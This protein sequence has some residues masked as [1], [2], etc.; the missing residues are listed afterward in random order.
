M[1][2]RIDYIRKDGKEKFYETGRFADEIRLGY[3]GISEISL[4]PVS[5]LKALKVLSL[6][7]NHIKN[8]DLSPLASCKNLREIYLRGN[9]LRSLN[10]R[11]LENLKHLSM[12]YLGHNKIRNLDL[13][14]LSTSTLL[15]KLDLLENEIETIDLTALYRTPSLSIELDNDV[16][17]TTFVCK[18]HYDPTTCEKLL[19]ATTAFDVPIQFNHFEDIRSVYSFL[20]KGEALWK[21]YH[22]FSQGMKLLNLDWLGIP[23]IDIDNGLQMLFRLDGNKKRIRKFREKMV[24]VVCEQIDEGKSTLLLEIEKAKEESQIA[25]RMQRILENK[26]MEMENVTLPVSDD[27]VNLKPLWL[28]SYGHEILQSLNRGL[29]CDIKELDDLRGILKKL[30]FELK[31]SKEVAFSGSKSISQP[32]QEYIHKIVE[33]RTQQHLM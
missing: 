11:P 9:Q 20:K 7:Y 26:S 18:G 30:G 21:K 16:K 17:A 14:P 8:L 12:I 31:V 13:F 3:L 4:E 33:L 5:S 29:Y 22:L 24:S 1:G 10:L 6:Q 19:K 27:T 15:L 23:D 28:T 32:L 2:V 25:K